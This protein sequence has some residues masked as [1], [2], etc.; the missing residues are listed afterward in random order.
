M[1]TALPKKNY[2]VKEAARLLGVSTNTLYKY[3]DEGKIKSRRIGQ[4][5]FKIP[6]KELQEFL[7]DG[8][9][10]AVAQTPQP[11]GMP[12]VNEPS[13]NSVWRVAQDGGSSFDS[14]NESVDSVRLEDVKQNEVTVTTD[15]IKSGVNDIVFFRIFKAVVFLG[16]GAIYLF[17][18][19]DLFGFDLDIL[20]TSNKTLFDLLPIGLLVAGGFNLLEV[21]SP[22]RFFGSHLFFDTFTVLV[23]TVF[24]YLSINSTQWGLF[25]FAVSFTGIALSHLITGAKG[26]LSN[27][28]FYDT[29]GKFVLF[30][31][32]TGGIVIVMSPT[33]FPVQYISQYIEDTKNTFVLLWF[34]LLATP[35]VYILSP[36]GR[37]SALKLPFLVLAS[38]FTIL[39]AINLTFS[40][41]WDTA[42]LAFLTGIFGFFL[43]W[44]ADSERILSANKIWIVFVTFI[45]VSSTIVFGL[46]SLNISRREI[47]LGVASSLDDSIEKLVENINDNFTEKA[48][49]LTHFAGT[50]ELKESITGERDDDVAIAQARTIYDQLGGVSRVIIYNGEGIAVGVYP[51]NSLFQGTNFSTQGYFSETLK[52]Y[53]PQIS[54]LFENIIGEPVI[55]QT[56]PVFEQNQFV[57]MIGVSYDLKNFADFIEI[58]SNYPYSIKG[59]DRGGFVVF[60]TDE[61]QVGGREIGVDSLSDSEFISV[62][63]SADI[64]R[65]NIY[66]NSEVGP[67]VSRISSLNI[68]LSLLLVINALFSVTAGIIAAKKLENSSETKGVVGSMLTENPR[69]V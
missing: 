68:T 67:A 48:S 39:I 66:L 27:I 41:R 34:L 44:W 6:A 33:S 29:F 19:N 5:R 62:T 2:S 45:W 50:P 28:G 7:G 53:R 54:P 13:E 36:N 58:S 18:G 32:V 43:S 24:T 10:L 57:G 17:S 42:Y 35:I 12:L 49:I 47:K 26:S 59:V 22:K 52:S 64:P 14:K 38:T 30:L 37:K 9:S 61:T 15:D 46:F 4:G 40:A 31:A 69:F 3:L 60:S 51:R 55:T 63:Q 11:V 8:D 20:S 56:E 23:L 16:L 25:V 65:W 1:P 21:I